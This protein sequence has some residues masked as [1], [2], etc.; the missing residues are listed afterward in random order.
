MIPPE[1]LTQKAR[2]LMCKDDPSIRS[3]D[4]DKLDAL[5]ELYIQTGIQVHSPGYMGRQFS[6]IVPLSASIDMVGSVVNQ[7]ASF[8][9]AGQLPN[10]AERIIAKEFYTFLGWEE[11]T[12]DMVS[13]SGGS[14]ANLTAMLAARNKAYPNIWKDGLTSLQGR[15]PAVAISDDYHYSLSRAAGILGIGENQ[16]IRLPLDEKRRIRPEMIESSLAQAKERGLDVFCLIASAGSTSVGAIDPIAE[17]SEITRKH[18]IWLHVDGAHGGSLLVSDTL[19]P[20]VKDIG[21]ADSFML[22]AHKMLFVPSPCTL[23]FYRKK[24]DAFEAFNQKASYVFDKEPDI[25]TEFDS[26][27]KNFECTKRPAIMNLW[28]V[29]ALYGKS[30]FA[31]K[32]EYLNGLTHAFHDLIASTEDFETIHEP[33]INI[34]CFRYHPKT[35]SHEALSTLQDEIRKRIKLEGRFFISKVDIDHVAALRVVFMNHLITAEHCEALLEAIRTTGQT[36]IKE[37]FSDEC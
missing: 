37:M 2:A 10:V 5:I 36:I 24:Q 23:L 17:I 13:T 6:G 3:I 27:P 35:M 32:I 21:M 12:G 30:L 26:A 7:P 20:Q 31:Q 1:E 15:V 14:L 25:Y 29:W 19:R 33:E 18:N 22:D 34:F 11:D 8:Y 9:E 4:E 28:A 16:L